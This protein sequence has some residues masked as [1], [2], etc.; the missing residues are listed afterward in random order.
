MY[1]T[2]GG[3]RLGAL[4]FMA[5]DLGVTV[6]PLG[7]GVEPR[8]TVEAMGNLMVEVAKHPFDLR[9]GALAYRGG[10]DM[11]A[12]SRPMVVQG[13][14]FLHRDGDDRHSMD[15]VQHRDRAS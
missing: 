5:R 12:R 2:G 14:P 4:R 8:I 10:T 13:Q 1:L 6:H 7:E 3:S 15:P 9:V 11:P